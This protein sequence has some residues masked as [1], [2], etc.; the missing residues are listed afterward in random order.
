MKSRVVR[1]SMLVALAS[2]LGSGS[3]LAQESSTKAAQT[4]TEAWLS[5]ID[6]QNYAASW[7]AA[8]SFFRTRVTQEQWQTAAQAGT[9]AV[10]STEIAHSEK[11]HVHHDSSGR[12]GWRVCGLPIH[13]EFR[14]ES[15]GS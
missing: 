4:A 1:F 13:D 10:W 7:D 8:A 11:R 6:N 12:T 3:I 5:L 14:A 2:I 9:S 15:G